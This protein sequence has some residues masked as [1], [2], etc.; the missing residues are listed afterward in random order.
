M[1]SHTCV[2]HE[3]DGPLLLYVYEA[4]EALESHISYLRI[5][6]DPGF[7]VAAIS[8]VKAVASVV[9]EG[10]DLKSPY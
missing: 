2:S 3:S 5:G 7:N 9:Q 8:A 4:S 1:S 6:T 10:A